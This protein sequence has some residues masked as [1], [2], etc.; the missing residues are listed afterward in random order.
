MY[1]DL[2]LWHIVLKGSLISKIK[3]NYA[4]KIILNKKYCDSYD[5]KPLNLEEKTN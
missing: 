5:W 2:I 4:R 3:D 1:V